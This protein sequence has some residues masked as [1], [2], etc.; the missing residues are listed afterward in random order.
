MAPLKTLIIKVRPAMKF[1]LEAQ[2]I[3]ERRTMSEVVRIALG[4]YLARNGQDDQV[5]PIRPGRPLNEGP[6]AA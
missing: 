2:A 3:R 6:E 4:E 1:Q 5:V